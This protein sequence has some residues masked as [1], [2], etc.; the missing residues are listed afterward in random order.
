MTPRVRWPLL[1]ICILAVLPFAA[2]AQNST[3]DGSTGT[4][5]GFS[6]PSL[7]DDAWAGPRLPAAE[8]L[9]QADQQASQ[10]AD[11]EQ[12]GDEQQQDA[13]EVTGLLVFLDCDRRI[14]DQDYLRQEITFINYVRDR[15]DSQIQILVTAQFG[16]ASIEYTFDF[17]GLKEFEGDDFRLVWTSSFT[18][19][20]DERREGIAQMIRAGVVHYI[21]KTPEIR[22]IEIREQVERA[23]RRFLTVD[24]SDDP[25]NFWVFRLSLNGEIGGEDRRSNYNMRFTG[26]AN[27]TTD[28]WKIRFNTN[29][30]NDERTFILND[31]SESIGTNRSWTFSQQT[32]KSLGDHW[33]LS[34]KFAAWQ[35][36]FTN[37]ER[38]FIG[39][40][41]IE[42]NIFPY[43]D[44]SR[45]IFTFTYEIG[46]SYDKYFEETIFMKTEETLYDQS[47]LVNLDVVQ[48][49]GELE[50]GVNLL[51]YLNHLDQW[52]A[53]L[54]GRI[55]FRIIRGLSFN[56]RGSWAAVRNQRYLPAEG[57]TDEEILLLQG[58]LATD[59][60]Y[61]VN[62]G[63]TYQFGSIFNNVVNPRFSD[64]RAGFGSTGFGGGGGGGRR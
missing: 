32:V 56:V 21:A 36:S 1:A 54:N 23:D 49:W 16:G 11:P 3:H 41:G 37:Q 9:Q 42:Y 31:G 51:Q 15:E 53:R 22:N 34:A 46:V 55:E 35:A 38:V 28:A 45:R 10:Q 25:W 64:N 7:P 57:Q 14:C 6:V 40:P 39:A 43:A 26:S 58:A 5:R 60:A 30:R 29:F 24:P 19:T 13:D 4:A 33:G 18:D 52:S 8:R 50:G 48:P 44:S 62:F 17:I 12:E 61:E 20:Q 2:E 63:V 27:R 47:L 59:S